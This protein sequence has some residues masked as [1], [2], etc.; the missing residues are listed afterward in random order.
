MEKLFHLT[1]NR[2]GL[3]FKFKLHVFIYYSVDFGMQA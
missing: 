3:Q 2:I 1:Q